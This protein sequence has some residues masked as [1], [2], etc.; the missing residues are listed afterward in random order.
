LD[1]VEQSSETKDRLKKKLDVL[2]E[3]ETLDDKAQIAIEDV[4]GFLNSGRSAETYVGI[5]ASEGS[6]KKDMN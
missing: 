1:C 4:L 6:K 2:N 3:I 5:F